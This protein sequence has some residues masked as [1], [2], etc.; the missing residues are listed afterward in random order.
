MEYI[1]VIEL[2]EIL[3]QLIT[4]NLFGLGIISILMVIN[5]LISFHTLKNIIEKNKDK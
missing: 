2:K 1:T 5:D 3:T 4:F